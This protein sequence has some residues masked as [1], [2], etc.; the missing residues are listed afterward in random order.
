MK[1]LRLGKVSGMSD[2][3][4]P[5]TPVELQTFLSA[6]QR[7]AKVLSTTAVL[8]PDVTA[9]TAIY[10]LDYRVDALEG[11][12]HRAL[13]RIAELEKRLES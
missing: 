2:A 12:L 3:N 10:R 4:D 1:T 9:E 7:H 11:V 5:K 13:D 6:A 8:R